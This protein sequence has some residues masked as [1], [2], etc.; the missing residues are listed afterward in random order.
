MILNPTND[1]TP[2]S[3][4]CFGTMQFGGHSSEQDA[5]QVYAACREAGINFFD[6]AWVYNNGA[7]EDILGRLIEHER[8]AVA[9]TTKG[10]YIGGAGAQNLTS[11]LDQSL[12]RLG[13]DYVDLYFLH[14]F[15]D[16]TPL[17]ETFETLAKFKDAGKIHQIGVS[18]YAAWQVMKAQQVAHSFD[19]R[20]DAIQP[21]YNLVKRQAEVE[22]LPMALSESIA[23]TPY[24]P[25]GGGLLSGKYTDENAGGRLV[26]NNRYRERYALDWMHE[27]G[28]DLA[29]L[30]K[31]WN[32]SPVTLA[33]QWVAAHPAIT[34]PIISGRNTAQI[35]PA[36]AAINAPFSEQQY[37]EISALSQKP[38][39]AT[40][41]LEEG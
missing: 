20:I 36:L 24:S 23:V 41:R 7:A 15:D 27:A 12:A 18:N 39:P 8:A 19:L 25:L 10:A 17:E 40:D 14:V 29:A 34:A 22:L 3:R 26:E 33:V 5:A 38:A 2:L 9:I 28:C 13:T 4:M 35:A 11:Q 31:Q 16:D 30:A 6:C 32:T 37:E 1:G 21:M